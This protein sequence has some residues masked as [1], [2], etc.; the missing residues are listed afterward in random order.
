MSLLLLV[1]AIVIDIQQWYLYSLYSYSNVWYSDI[2]KYSSI[3][4]L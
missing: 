2:V 3:V 4:I 1:F